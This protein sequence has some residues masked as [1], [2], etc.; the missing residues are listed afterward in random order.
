MLMQIKLKMQIKFY[1][2]IPALSKGDWI[3]GNGDNCWFTDCVKKTLACSQMF[4][5][6]LLSSSSSSAFPAIPQGFTIS[7]EIFAYMTDLFFN[8]S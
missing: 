7:G 2:L 4:M 5:N 1:F 6:Q 8:P 3:N